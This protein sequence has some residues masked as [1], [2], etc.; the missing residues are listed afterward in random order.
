MLKL[1]DYCPEKILVLLRCV[2]RCVLLTET[3]ICKWHIFIG[4]WQHY[5][6]YYQHK[7]V[8]SFS[9]LNPINR[10]LTPYYEKQTHTIIFPPPCLTVF[11]I[12]WAEFRI[13]IPADI[14]VFG[15]QNQKYSLHR[16]CSAVF[17]FSSK[18]LSDQPNN[19]FSTNR[20]RSV[21]QDTFRFSSPGWLKW[22]N[23]Y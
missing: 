20:L 7:C 2:L 4:V 16:I 6:I 12:F 1:A 10:G 15:H 8:D 11:R 19:R 18:L 14:R 13:Y 9:L 21:R 3:S 22:A 17:K 23:L 5:H